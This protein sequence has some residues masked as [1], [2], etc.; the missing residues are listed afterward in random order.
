MMIMHTSATEVMIRL[1]PAPPRASNTFP[2]RSRMTGAA[3]ERGRLPPAI[4]LASEGGK[5]NEL[6][7]KGM[8]KSS[9]SLFRMIP[10]T[11]HIFLQPH[12]KFTVEVALTTIPSRS[13]VVRC[14]VPWLSTWE[15]SSS[16]R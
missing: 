13:L 2:S 12:S 16:S 3:E 9:T 4:K 5:P 8:E 7:A 11:G 6:L 10:V 14:V 15:N 1:P